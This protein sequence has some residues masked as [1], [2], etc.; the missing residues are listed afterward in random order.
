MMRRADPDRRIGDLARPG[1]RV[2]DQFLER[3][4]RRGGGRGQHPL[5]GGRD[6]DG[7][8]AA[9]H[10]ERQRLA[11]CRQH[12]QRGVRHQQRV[13]VRRRLGDRI[14]P[15]DPAAARPRLDDDALMP[16]LRQPGGDD[17]RHQIVAAARR[18]L[19]DDPDQ[20]ARI[21][22]RL[23]QG[24]SAGQRRERQGLLPYYSS[25]FG[26]PACSAMPQGRSEQVLNI[27]SAAKAPLI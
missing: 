3:A 19:M 9:R 4:I 16:A 17:A 12:R 6:D 10:I 22:F 7:R 14:C 11:E 26:S 15:D 13:A 20:P 23:R 2:G 24:G 18:I 25:L 8:K 27:P 1:G 21:D 5:A